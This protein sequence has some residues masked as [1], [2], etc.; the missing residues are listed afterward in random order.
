MGIKHLTQGIITDIKLKKRG[1]RIEVSAMPGGKV[2]DDYG[3]MFLA[4]HAVLDV[5]ADET[6]T[7]GYKYI[8]RCNLSLQSSAISEPVVRQSIHGDV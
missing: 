6:R 4:Q 8:H 7:T 2:I 3:F 5:R 1:F